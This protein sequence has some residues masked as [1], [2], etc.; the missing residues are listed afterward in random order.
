[1]ISCVSPSR[2][3][4][5][6][7]NLN[8]EKFKEIVKGESSAY[9][10]GKINPRQITIKYLDHK[11][12]NDSRSSYYY[13]LLDKFC[14]ENIN[15]ENMNFEIT[16]K[17]DQNKY[18]FIIDE[19]NRGEISKIL[20]ELFFSIDPGY[21]GKDGEISLQYSREEEEKFYIPKNL[22]IIGTM[23]DIDRSV[24]SFDFAMRR[25]FTFIEIEPND[26]LEM[27]DENKEI[28][29][30]DKVS[31]KSRMNSLNEFIK[32]YPGLGPDYRIGPAYF[33]KIKDYKNYGDKNKWELL[34]RYNLKPLIAEYIKGTDLFD[35]NFN[36]VMNDFYDAY[37]LKV[38]PKQP[39]ENNG[40]SE[41][42]VAENIENNNSNENYDTE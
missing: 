4:K 24:D 28:D 5:G 14:E 27:I 25:R 32:N 3:R 11:G 16:E 40:I 13:S 2:Q 17:T 41:I 12:T 39:S 9:I 19:I 29:E 33:L 38:K 20:G 35:K 21:R 23:N 31:A 30:N 37:N 36:E 7:E 22:Y 34:W 10:N 18:V 6:P 26:R 15:E 8:I 42:T 1:M